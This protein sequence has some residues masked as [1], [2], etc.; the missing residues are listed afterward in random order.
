MTKEFKE[1]I[2]NAWIESGGLITQKLASLITDISPP[3]INRKINN[4][5][6]RAWKHKNL[7]RPLVSFQDAISL[8]RK[9]KKTK[10]N[11]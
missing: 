5:E 10:K 8:K 6:L 2:K 11:K 3:E 1:W 9:R 7:K 4:G